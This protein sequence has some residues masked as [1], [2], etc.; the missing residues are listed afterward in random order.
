[1]CSSKKYPLR[2]PPPA[3]DDKGNSE[4]RG[5]QKEVISEGVWVSYRGFIPGGLSKV[6]LSY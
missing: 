4:R 2:P 6:G 5:V 3:K 1:M